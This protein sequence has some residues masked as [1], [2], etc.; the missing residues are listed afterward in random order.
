M[1]KL[2][3]FA[4]RTSRV[5]Q[6]SLSYDKYGSGLPL[7]LVNGSF[8]DHRTNWEFLKPLLEKQFTVYAIARPGRGKTDATEGHRLEDESL[9]VVTLIQAINEPVFLL[10]HSYDAQVAVN[11]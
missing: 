9:N 10:G 11:N 3:A 2:C 5:R 1:C 8:S 4:A 7:V 6:D